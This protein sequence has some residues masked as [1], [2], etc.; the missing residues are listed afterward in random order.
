MQATLARWQVTCIYLGVYSS[1]G[2]GPG[3]ECL[4]QYVETWLATGRVAFI[5]PS[6]STHVYVCVCVCVCVCVP[7]IAICQ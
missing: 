1:V 6:S 2:A 5:L 3:L 4:L 7:C